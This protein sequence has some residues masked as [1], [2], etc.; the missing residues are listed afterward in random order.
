[1]TTHGTGVAHWRITL[2]QV[3]VRHAVKQ[4]CL[5]KREQKLVYR[6][7]SYLKKRV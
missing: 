1:M 2:T 5:A 7:V 3:Q 4:Q 6:G